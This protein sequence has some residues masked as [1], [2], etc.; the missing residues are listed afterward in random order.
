MQLLIAKQVTKSADRTRRKE[1][2]DE[3][4]ALLRNLRAPVRGNQNED[5]NPMPPDNDDW[6]QLINDYWKGM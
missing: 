5:E 1:G 4:E 2:D 6:Q 3:Q